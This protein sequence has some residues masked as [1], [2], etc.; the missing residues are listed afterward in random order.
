MAKISLSNYS[1][2]RPV[3]MSVLGDTCIYV[4][5]TITAI[6]VGADEKLIAYISLG[7]GAAGY[8][9]TKLYKATTEELEHVLETQKNEESQN[10][11]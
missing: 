6:A 7:F 11:A 9:F 8:F 2:P 3:W 1:K 5:T 4:S 10:P